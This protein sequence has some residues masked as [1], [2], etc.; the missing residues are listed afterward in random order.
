[1]I[2]DHKSNWNL[3]FSINRTFFDQKN[4]ELLILIKINWFYNLKKIYENFDFY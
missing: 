3:I 4:F 1:M 2:D